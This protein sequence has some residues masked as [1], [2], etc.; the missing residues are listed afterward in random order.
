MASA[1]ISVSSIE[2]VASS[3]GTLSYVAAIAGSMVSV[4][5]IDGAVVLADFQVSSNASLINDIIPRIDEA[6]DV[7]LPGIIVIESTR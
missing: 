5:E 2:S 7:I 6:R 4:S 1:E 3:G